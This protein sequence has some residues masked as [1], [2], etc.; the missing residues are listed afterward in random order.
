MLRLLTAALAHKEMQP[1]IY[2]PTP[3]TVGI[4]LNYVPKGVI[5]DISE[6]ENGYCVKL[7]DMPAGQQQPK[8]IL[9]ARA[10]FINEAAPEWVLCFELFDKHFGVDEQ[11][12]N[13]DHVAGLLE[14][15]KAKK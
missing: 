8:A 10:T 7:F 9:K 13:A 11:N 5:V 2:T 14:D 1:V 12:R 4:Q 15:K 6:I 3:T